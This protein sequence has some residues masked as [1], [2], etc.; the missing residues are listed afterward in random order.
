[1]N[2]WKPFLL[3]SWTV[4]SRIKPH[5]LA[6]Y[7]G[8]RAFEKVRGMISSGNHQFVSVLELNGRP[9]VQNE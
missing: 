8:R 3:K 1:M 4:N 7:Y 5:C 6:L 9:L 2:K